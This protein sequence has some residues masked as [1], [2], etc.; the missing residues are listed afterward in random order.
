[1]VITPSI[2]N[3]SE[4]R[5][6]TTDGETLS[7]AGYDFHAT[8][9]SGNDCE[10]QTRYQEMLKAMLEDQWRWIKDN[11][12]ARTIDD[13]NAIAALQMAEHAKAVAQNFNS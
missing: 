10:K 3:H 12:H 7:L 5:T 1:L 11:G 2:T 8:I 13:N 4:N 6:E 9:E